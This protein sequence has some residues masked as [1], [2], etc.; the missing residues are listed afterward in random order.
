MHAAPCT[1][2]LAG[3]LLSGKG[4][5][6]FAAPLSSLVF[7]SRGYNAVCWLM[8]SFTVLGGS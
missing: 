1:T 7:A 2:L 6:A 8:D 3:G 4:D 5:S